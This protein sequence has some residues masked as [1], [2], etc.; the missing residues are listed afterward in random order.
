MCK[1]SKKQFFRIRKKII[2]LKDSELKDRKV[3]IEKEITDLP[4]FLTSYC[5]FR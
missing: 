3:K 2:V 5:V 4:I 1:K